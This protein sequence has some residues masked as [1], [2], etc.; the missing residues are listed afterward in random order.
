MLSSTVKNLV[1]LVL[2]GC[3]AY[4]IDVLRER[5]ATLEKSLQEKT[6]F[7]EKCNSLQKPYFKDLSEALR[8]G[9]RLMEN[10]KSLR[11][12]SEENKSWYSNKLPADVVQLLTTKLPD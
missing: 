5:C 8:E 6:E 9:S 1:L 3:A 10:A 7:F 11:N 12:T 4:Y 2:I